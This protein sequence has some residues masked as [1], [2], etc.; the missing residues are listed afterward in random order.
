MA[1]SL[2]AL[3]IP[4]IRPGTSLRTVLVT[5]ST[6]GIALGIVAAFAAAGYDVVLHGD[7]DGHEVAIPKLRAFW[8]RWLDGA[9]SR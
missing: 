4:G 7:G 9:V 1:L 6:G 3:S 2:V 8:R 5:G